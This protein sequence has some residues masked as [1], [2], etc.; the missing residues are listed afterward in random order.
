[1]S[2][3]PAILTAAASLS[4]AELDR[5][6]SWTASSFRKAGLGPGDIVGIHLS[7]QVQHLMTSLALARL[8]AGQFV[9]KDTD[10]PRLCHEI[11]RSLKIVATVANESA[12]VET[13]TSRVD[14]PADNLRDFKGLKPIDVQP[15][16]DGSLPFLVM[17]SSGTTG[18]PK[19][20]LL[21]H[22]A[23][24]ARLGPFT[25]ELPDGPGSRFL[26]LTDVGFH[27]A[28]QRVFRGLTSGGCVS[29][30]HEAK[31]QAL[32]E[33]VAE[34]RIN[35]LFGVPIHAAALLRISKENAYLFP[36]VEAFL[37][38]ST[39]IPEALRREIQAR[40]TP[41]LYIVYATNEAGNVSVAP[42]AQVRSVPGVVGKLVPGMKA[43]VIGDDGQPLPPG[44]VGNIRLKSAGIIDGYFDAPTETAKAFRD[45][46][47]YP[48][49]LVEFT[50]NFELIHHG[51]ADDL[52]ILDGIN[53]YPAEIENVLLQHRAVAEAAAFPLPS[54]VHGNIPAAAVVIRS[55]ASVDKLLSHCRSWLGL[56]APRGLIIVPM[57]PR[58]AV[59]KVQKTELARMF[60]DQ[61]HRKS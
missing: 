55:E 4:Y 18:A 27:G 54:Q 58:N 39:L 16:D 35:Y 42:P 22:A 8:G 33:F 7:N 31:P 17:R 20:I 53:I 44:K 61:L 11:T 2:D 51:R 13:G 45:G 52:M 25:H 60:R 14:P 5:A 1:M 9:F 40:L 47:F 59:G 12:K 6:V 10:P 23:A 32:V 57:L 21:T 30:L 29:L 28:K 46:W 15:T 19:V 48:G 50:P 26:T 36:G 34:H 3:A 49:D 37:V 43:E 38:G 24:L 41:N 56:H